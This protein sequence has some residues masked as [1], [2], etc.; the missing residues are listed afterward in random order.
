MTDTEGQAGVRCHNRARG[1]LLVIRA[2]CQAVNR[3][4]IFGKHGAD[5]G[6]RLRQDLR[7]SAA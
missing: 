2:R 1:S 7:Q 6:T 5:V 4:S 3:I